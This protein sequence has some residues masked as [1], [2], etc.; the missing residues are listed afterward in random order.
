MRRCTYRSQFDWRVLFKAPSVT[1]RGLHREPAERPGRAIVSYPGLR[2]RYGAEARGTRLPPGSDAPQGTLVHRSARLLPHQPTL[3]AQRPTIG[4]GRVGGS[5]E[6]G[7][8]D[9]LI[10]FSTGNRI[11]RASNY[12]VR[13]SLAFTVCYPGTCFGRCL[14]RTRLQRDGRRRSCLAAW[15][16]YSTSI[17]RAFGGRVGRSACSPNGLTL[18]RGERLGS[19]STRGCSARHCR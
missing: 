19:T 14:I 15:W 3:V 10:A 13:I 17:I 5:G 4:I 11:G 16:R 9:L 7:S 1:W 12:G 18:G 2:H 8:A 6:H